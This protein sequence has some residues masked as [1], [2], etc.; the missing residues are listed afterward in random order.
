[1]D[2]LKEILN[3]PGV[4]FSVTADSSQKFCALYFQ[5]EQQ[6]IIM[7]RY[8]EVLELDATYKVCI[9]LHINEYN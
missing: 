8:G 7:Y 3:I 1:M 4:H 6:R 5:T 2:N 9:L